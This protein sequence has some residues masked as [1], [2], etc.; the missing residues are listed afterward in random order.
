MGQAPKEGWL[1][2]LLPKKE[3]KYSEPS[4]FNPVSENQPSCSSEALIPE[5]SDSLFDY[6]ET[7]K[8]MRIQLTK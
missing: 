7:K 5:Q 3:S 2:P 1:L 4:N 8:N 6:A